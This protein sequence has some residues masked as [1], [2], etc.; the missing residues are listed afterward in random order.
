MGILLWI[1]GVALWLVLAGLVG[2]W[3]QRKGHSFWIGFLVSL[4]FSLII[5]VVVVILLKDKN[6]GRR[7]VVTW[8]AA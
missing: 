8:N 3:G 5:G 7:G 4:I 2:G 6:T 1:I